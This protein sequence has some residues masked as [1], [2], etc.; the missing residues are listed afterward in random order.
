METQM[1]TRACHDNYI[2]ANF[3]SKRDRKCNDRPLEHLPGIESVEAV[4]RVTEACERRSKE[5]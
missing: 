5:K 4:A 2:D 3:T 1:I